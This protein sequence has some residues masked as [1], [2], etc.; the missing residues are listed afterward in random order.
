M[1]IDALL[2]TDRDGNGLLFLSDVGNVN[3]EHIDK[4]IIV[5]FNPV[6][7]GIGRKRQITMFPKYSHEV[8]KIKGRVR[9]YS[10][11]NG[12]W[13]NMM[14]ETFVCPSSVVRHL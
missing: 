3:F 4:G 13:S 8:G 9:V 1:E 12:K 14:K 6:V 11:E 7:S 10:V 5:S 2:C